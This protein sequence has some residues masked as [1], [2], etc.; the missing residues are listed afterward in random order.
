VAHAAVIVEA[1]NNNGLPDSIEEFTETLIKLRDFLRAVVGVLEEVV[2]IVAI[3][4]AA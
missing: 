2:K 1:K 4:A 3:V